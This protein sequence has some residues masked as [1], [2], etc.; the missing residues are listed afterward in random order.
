MNNFYR[1]M[2][3]FQLT[4]NSKTHQY[5]EASGNRSRR[6]V[7]RSE[8]A[9]LQCAM[10]HPIGHYNDRLERLGKFAHLCEATFFCFTQNIRNLKNGPRRILCYN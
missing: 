8:S 6:S 3:K 5:S 4:Q 10:F 1:I 7:V 2:G 9:T